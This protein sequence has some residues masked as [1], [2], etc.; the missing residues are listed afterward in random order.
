MIRNL[1]VD[2]DL[3]CIR[4][5]A[6]GRREVAPPPLHRLADGAE[7]RS[8]QR[9]GEDAVG[10]KAEEALRDRE[11][12]AKEKREEGTDHRSGCGSGEGGA[13]GGRPPLDLLDQLEAS[14]DDGGALD[15]KALVGELVHGPL[16]VRVGL[17]GRDHLARAQAGAGPRVD[18]LWGRG[19]DSHVASSP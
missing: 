5:H 17:V 1:T 13:A 9:A 16:R 19:L 4:V 6:A 7:H 18:L 14:A 3:V 10:E 11:E 2:L 8:E 15:G 12:E